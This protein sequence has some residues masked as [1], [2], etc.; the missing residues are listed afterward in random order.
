MIRQYLQNVENMKV[1]G[2]E[3]KKEFIMKQFKAL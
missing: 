2:I 1:L 3:E